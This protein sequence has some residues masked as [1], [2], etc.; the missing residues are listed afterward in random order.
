[1]EKPCYTLDSASHAVLAI[2]HDRTLLGAFV[3][4][5]FECLCCAG[6][7]LN[8]IIIEPTTTLLRAVFS[9]ISIVSNDYGP[10]THRHRTRAFP[11]ASGDSG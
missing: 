7:L 4:Q 11:S 2:V 6:P 1:M 9:T 8:E 5:F 10:L 3:Q